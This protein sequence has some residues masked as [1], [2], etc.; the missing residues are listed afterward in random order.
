MKNGRKMKQWGCVMLALMSGLMLPGIVQASSGLSDIPKIIDGKIYY[1]GIK[2]ASGNEVIIDRDLNAGAV[3]GYAYDSGDVEANSNSVAVRDST[4]AYD[5]YSGYAYSVQGDATANKNSVT[6]SGGTVNTEDN[7]N[8]KNKY[9]KSTVFTG[10]FCRMAKIWPK[11]IAGHEKH[12][13]LFLLSENSRHGFGSVFSH[14]VYIVN[15]C[16]DD[17]FYGVSEKRCHGLHVHAVI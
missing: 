11:I 14:I 8:I 1:V 12:G 13:R 5:I 15:V 6:I 17:N 16:A 4:V 2:G 10:F 7:K 9:A 3:G